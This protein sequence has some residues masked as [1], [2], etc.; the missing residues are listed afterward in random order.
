M[1]FCAWTRGEVYR[2]H[3]EHGKKHPVQ[4]SYLM[5][6]NYI[7]VVIRLQRIFAVF[8]L[9]RNTTSRLCNHFKNIIYETYVLIVIVRGTFGTYFLIPHPVDTSVVHMIANSVNSVREH[10]PLGEGSLYSWSPV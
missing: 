7:M 4:C 2:N 1:S 9:H 3:F 5:I 10:S 6:H 8:L